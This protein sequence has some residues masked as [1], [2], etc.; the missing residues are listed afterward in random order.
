MLKRFVFPAF[1][2]IILGIFSNYINSDILISFISTISSIILNTLLILSPFI[3]F[4][5]II[6]AINA[7]KDN[8]FFYFK[9]FLLIIIPLFIF[10][11]LFFYFIKII[12]P[13]VLSNNLEIQEFYLSKF[14]F[15]SFFEN[16]INII[17]QI[18]NFCT[19]KLLPFS[20]ILS[21]IIGFISIYNKKIDTF[22]NHKLNHFEKIL[23]NFILKVIIP[24]MPIWIIS[25]FAKSSYSY[26]Q[27]SLIYN[28]FVMSIIIFLAQFLF[29]GTMYYFCAK[30][31]KINFFKIIKQAKNLYI[32]TLSMM[33]LGSN[34]IIPFS[35]NAQSALGVDKNYAKLIAASAFNLPG[36]FIAN[37]GFSYGIITIF[38]INVS[39]FQFVL[40]IFLLIIATIIAPTLPLGVFSITQ[41]LLTPILGF[42]TQNIELMGT[43]YYNQG[44]TNACCNNCGDIYL[45]LL[46]KKS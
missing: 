17:N 38:N 4:I 8:Y 39:D 16:I 31:N 26:T 18:K 30:I 1:L 44:T 13:F 19:N 14:S 2:G 12:Y 6:N 22:V 29:L 25:I 43:L 5:S 45:G 7:I 36:S 28:D 10:G 24:I 32:D 40:Y 41:Q 20:L 33:G 46:T 37:I 23:Y 11:L 3:I 34:L 9:L 42:T 27:T 35:V 15:F 21:T